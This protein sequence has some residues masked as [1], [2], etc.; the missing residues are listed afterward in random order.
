M[1]TNLKLEQ[2]LPKNSR[3]ITIT[4]AKQTFVLIAITKLDSIP[5]CKHNQSEAK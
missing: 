4:I 1:L 3:I 5:A 2:H